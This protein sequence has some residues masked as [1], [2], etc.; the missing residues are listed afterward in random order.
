MA[1]YVI[2]CDTSHWSGAINFE[3]MYQAGARYWITKASD[4]KRGSGTLFEDTMFDQYCR[5][6]FTHGKLLAGGFHW[7]QPDADPYKAADFYLERYKR[8][9]FHFPPVLDF[10]EIYAYQKKNADGNIVP[11]GLESHY[12][13]CAQVWLE[14]VERATGRKPIVYTAKWFTDH[15]EKRLLGFLKAYP[16]WV[17][18]YPWLFIPG[19]SKP[20]MPYPWDAWAIWQYSA[21]GNRKGHEYGVAAGDIDL[22][23][24]PGSYEDLL[25]WLNMEAPQPQPPMNPSGKWTILMLGNVAIRNE[26]TTIGTSIVRYALQGDVLTATEKTADNWYKVGDDEWMSGRTKWTQIT[27]ILEPLPPDPEPEPEPEHD[28][29]WLID[30]HESPENH[31]PIV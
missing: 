27:E 28:L 1:E 3:T 10:E 19:I 2:G 5:Q 25:G 9:P 15:F 23:Y 17:A 20:S 6:A 12:C 4:S 21:D 16:L 29:A 24:Y 30:M 14:R 7:L 31:P 26:P 11:T 13:W 22:N 18:Q 8:F